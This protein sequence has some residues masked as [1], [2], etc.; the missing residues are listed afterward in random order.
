MVSRGT[1]HKVFTVWFW[2]LCLT[3]VYADKD[4]GNASKLVWTPG[5]LLEYGY[6]LCTTWRTPVTPGNFSIYPIVL[7]LYAVIL[8]GQCTISSSW[9]L[10]STVCRVL[11]FVFFSAV[12]SPADYLCDME[13]FFSLLTGLYRLGDC[14]LILA[15]YARKATFNLRIFWC[16]KSTV[17]YNYSQNKWHWPHPMWHQ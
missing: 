3:D 5:T 13:L 12:C 17:Q 9:K 2:N 6:M 15:L 16:H 14:K 10:A 11:D 8:S 4:R 1:P 7:F